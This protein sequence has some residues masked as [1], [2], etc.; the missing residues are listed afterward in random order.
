[1]KIQLVTYKEPD[2]IILTRGSN[3]NTEKIIN[4]LKK[5]IDSVKSIFQEN[6]V[7]I[8]QISVIDYSLHQ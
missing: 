5:E 1:M 2:I 4:R 7:C 6:G 3:E 8:P